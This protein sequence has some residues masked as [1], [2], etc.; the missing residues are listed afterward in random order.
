MG[1]EDD[2][3]KLMRRTVICVSALV[4]LS[5]TFDWLRFTQ[6]EKVVSERLNEIIVP[7]RLNVTIYAIHG[8]SVVEGIAV[9]FLGLLAI[10]GAVAFRHMGMKWAAAVAPLCGLAITGIAV[11]SA[12]FIS[13]LAGDVQPEHIRVGFGLWF[14]VFAGPLILAVSSMMALEVFRPKFW[15]KFGRA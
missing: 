7:G 12:I 3:F 5:T 10:G 8:T 1:A 15:T 4:M 2:I 9:F 6:S 11:Y 14:I 13:G